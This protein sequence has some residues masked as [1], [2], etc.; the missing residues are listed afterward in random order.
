MLQ[1]LKKSLE[2]IQDIRLHIY[3]YIYFFLEGGYNQA[4]S[5]HL[6]HKKDFFCN[7]TKVTFIPYCPYHAAKVEQ[8]FLEHIF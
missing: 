5:I 6:A 1:S 7:F 2:H 8:K 4:K 3:I